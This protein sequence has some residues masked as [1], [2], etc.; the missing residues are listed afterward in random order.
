MGADSFLSAHAAATA[1][2]VFHIEGSPLGWPGSELLDMRADNEFWSSALPV[3]FF[4]EDAQRPLA[5]HHPGQDSAG[6]TVRS[7]T[8]STPPAPRSAASPAAWP[9][10]RSA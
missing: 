3:G 9:R 7:T 5:L 2:P 8:W 1:G 4:M 6:T 10:R